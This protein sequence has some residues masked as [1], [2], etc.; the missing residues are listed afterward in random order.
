MVAQRLRRRPPALTDGLEVEEAG[1]SVG[2]DAQPLSS[3][4]ASR[5]RPPFLMQSC[6]PVENQVL[7]DDERRRRMIAVHR[8][9]CSEVLPRSLYFGGQRAADNPAELSKVGV[10][11]LVNLTDSVDESGG[12]HMEHLVWPLSDHR[13]EDIVTNLPLVITWIDLV[14][15]SGGVVFVHCKEGV[16]RSSAVVIAYLMFKF[17][18]PFEEALARVKCSR[19]TACPNLGFSKQLIALEGRMGLGTPVLVPSA[20]RRAWRI[21]ALDVDERSLLRLQPLE[22]GFTGDLDS[23][24]IITEY[25]G[26]GEIW[27]GHRCPLPYALCLGAGCRYL[28]ALGVVEGRSIML[29]P[30]TVAQAMERGNTGYDSSVQYLESGSN[31]RPAI[32]SEGCPVAQCC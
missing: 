6:S 24:A 2:V 13:T 12:G 23:T 7:P 18:I 30:I 20:E 4:S 31:L 32:A 29:P 14:I 1:L 15:S 28:K 16:S 19:P 9:I 11:H 10:T 5:R 8:Q 17:R 3:P 25:N 21:V 22:P 27:V 26:T